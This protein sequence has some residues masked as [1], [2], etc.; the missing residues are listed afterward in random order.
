MNLDLIHRLSANNIKLSVADGNLKIN[1]PKGALTQE[2]LEEIK[3]NKL[4]LMSLLSSKYERIPLAP[5]EENYPVT[6]S[7]KRF[8]ILS[9]F[10]ESNAAYNIATELEFHGNLEK[11]LFNQA[12]KILIDRHESLRTFFQED[13]EENLKQYIVPYDEIQFA[14]E[15]E[16]VSASESKKEAAILAHYTHTFDL[17]K[18]PLFKVKVLKV[19]NEKYIL[20]FNMHHII[21]DGWSMEIVVREVIYIYNILL[22]GK[23]VALPELS[24]QYKDYAIWL[25]K[26]KQQEQLQITK[27]YW[28]EKFKEEIPALDFPYVTKR[29]QM[30]TYNGTIYEHQF[31]ENFHESLTT[32]TQKFDASLFMGL[33]A[34]INGLFYRYTNSTDITLGTVVAGRSHADLENQIGLFLNTL[35]IRTKFDDAIGFEKLLELQ[36]DTLLEAYKYQALPFDVLVDELEIQKDLSRSPLFD[37]MVILQNQRSIANSEGDTLDGIIVKKYKKEKKYS[38]CDMT[39]S[40]TESESHLGLSIEYNTD[41][42][43]ED[44]VKMLVNHLER[45]ISN[46]IQS[47]HKAIANISY[48][49]NEEIKQLTLINNATNQ[50]YDKS[51]TIITLFKETVVKSPNSIALVFND[52]QLTY[53]ELD[54]Q[55]DQLAAY[56]LATYSIEIEDII[57]VQLIRTEWLI[58]TLLAIMKT[59]GAYLP[60]DPNFP[61]D[62]ISYM[63]TDSNC[64]L[65]ITEA[66]LTEFQNQKV[67]LKLSDINLSAANL[68]YVIY[69]SGSTGKPKGVMLEHQNVVSFLQNVEEK[70]KFKNYTTV[71]ATTNV[72]FDISVLEIFG[73]ICTG[74]KMIL[75]SE[76]QLMSPELFIKTLQDHNIEILQTTPSRFS[77]LWEGIL[78]ESL[79]FLKLLLI[80]GEAFPEVLF[81]NKNTFKDIEIINVY[82]PTETSI[83]STVLD[84][85]ESDDLHIGKPLRNEQAY[86]LAD[87]LSPKPQW[88]VGELCIAGDG[89]GRGYLNKEE[90]TKE[91]FINNPFKLNE[92][93]YKTGD[94][95]RWLPNGNIDFIGRKDDQVKL[96]GYRIELGEIEHKLLST[97]EIKAAV[98]K[99][100]Q[101]NSGIKELVAYVISDGKIDV[102]EIRKSLLSVLPQYMIPNH[103]MQLESF[104]LTASGKLDK[105]QLPK[106]NESTKISNE[107]IAPRNAMEEKIVA[108]WE[109]IL[110][111]KNI[112]IFD[113]FLELGGQSIKIIKMINQVNKEFG[114]M[115]NTSDFYKMLTV[116][117]LVVEIEN[118]I[119]QVATPDVSEVVDRIII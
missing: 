55:S 114:V 9:Q 116:S 40:F 64:K 113:D 109:V 8:W 111:R 74:R 1:A 61:V 50:V 2:L 58:I 15:I 62:R 29:Q 112:G 20:L 41:I 24:I 53:E 105:N 67:D 99:I 5:V 17:S 60:I 11:K 39:F 81:K 69:T 79:P 47:P 75:F 108:I 23:P 78:G 103:I 6:S 44:F 14:I 95:A 18:A 118:Q 87:D 110:N 63:L 100:Y 119:W 30:K 107:Y 106:P 94:L 73:T 101:E 34:G 102:T 19:V 35:A 13:S 68:S 27:E 97:P 71:A 28:L 84:I 7:Q 25:S 89:V 46:G 42:Y 66:I 21:G 49:S 3:S 93:L 92:R 85:K 98:V 65:N 56:L 36:K 22:Q 82:G 4:S 51:K 16:D 104:P 76:K 45:F 26:D 88:V 86:I 70:L 90:L 72:V 32:Y 12:F 77:L 83:W 38:Q 10:G 91:K 59:G 117:D 31:S 43:N 33:M 96:N 37:F 80:G 57:G 115:I 48:L 52:L 54:T